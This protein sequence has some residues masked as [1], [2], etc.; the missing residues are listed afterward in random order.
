MREFLLSDGYIAGKRHDNAMTICD[1]GEL[2]TM[3]P[4]EEK[5]AQVDDDSTESTA[6]L[7]ER[8]T[9]QTGREWSQADLK[10][11]AK[12]RQEEKF[13]AEKSAPQLSLINASK[14][15]DMPGAG[16]EYG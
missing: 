4:S 10:V 1:D 6:E 14:L 11:S 16:S 2:R 9:P 15:D 13:Y 8:S 7:S 3:M 12:I 5:L